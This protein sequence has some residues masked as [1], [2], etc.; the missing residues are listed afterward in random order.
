MLVRIQ[1]KE[2]VFKKYHYKYNAILTS[3]FKKKYIQQSSLFKAF[4]VV[5]NKKKQQVVFFFILIFLLFGKSPKIVKVKKKHEYRFLGYTIFFNNNV[6]NQFISF[7]FPILDTLELVSCASN[8]NAVNLIF[9]EFPIL[10]EID[11]YCEKNSIFL[12]YIKA[13]NFIF[14]IQNYNNYSS[15]YFLESNIR[16]LKLPY[17]NLFRIK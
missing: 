17:S 4:F 5:K 16:I 7:Y 14:Q 6:L 11:S 12:D 13:Y 2:I 15:W 1:R 10:Y 3:K 8:F 9:K